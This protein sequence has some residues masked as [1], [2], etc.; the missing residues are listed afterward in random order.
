MSVVARG[1]G[2]EMAAPVRACACAP[3]QS[4]IACPPMRMARSCVPVA[5]MKLVRASTMLRSIAIMSSSS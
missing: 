3:C 2:N 4:R 1:I 5:M